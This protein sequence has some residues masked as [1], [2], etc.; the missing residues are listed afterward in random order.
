[1]A[2]LATKSKLSFFF[3]WTSNFLSTLR[4][5][6]EIRVDSLVNGWVALLL[7][8]VMSE[9]ADI[10]WCPHANNPHHTL[11]K[12]LSEIVKVVVVFLEDNGSVILRQRGCVLGILSTSALLEVLSDSEWM[13]SVDGVLLTWPKIIGMVPLDISL[14]SSTV[15]TC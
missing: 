6:N 5:K 4:P 11:L 10:I 7:T 14:A 2:T 1:M 15:V 13:L 3:G 12:W 9:P 8:S